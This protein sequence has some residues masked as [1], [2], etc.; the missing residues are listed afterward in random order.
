MKVLI[1]GCGRLG[2]GIARELFAKGNE[3]SVID[4]DPNSFYL[5]GNEFS[6]NTVI[7]MGYDKNVLEE[8]GIQFQN[9]VIC[10][11]GSDEINA[12]VGKIAKDHYMIPTVIARLY[13]PNKAKVY[14][15]LGIKA[16]S[17]TG[18]GVDRTIELLSFDKMDSVSLLGEQGDTEIIRIV[19]TSEVEGA[20]ASE[21]TNEDEY[22]LIAIV[23]GKHS[24][25]PSPD[26]EI[27]TG[28]IL[29]FAVVTNF[30]GK[31]KRAL[32]L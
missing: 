1:I 28:D 24:F 4:Q 8:A 25:L 21:L 3:I 22:R 7:G 16:V 18:Y 31:L 2:A 11:T 19:A 30:K 26:D 13:D 14:Q 32:G 20:L 27:R 23:R 15:T 29:Y 9:A 12:L 10:S 6:G 17:T 5:L